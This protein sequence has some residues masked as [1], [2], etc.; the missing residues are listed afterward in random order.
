M[1]KTRPPLLLGTVGVLIVLG[2]VTG[3]YR[4]AAPEVTMTP[5]GGAEAVPS[6]QEQAATA[7]AESTRAA[8]MAEETPTVESPTSPPPTSTPPPTGTTPEITAAPTFTPA[9]TT[10]TPTAVPSSTGQTTHVVQRGENLFRIALRYG[11][12][13]NAVASANGIANPALIYVGQT[14][15]I[16]AP[17]QTPSPPPA[18]GTTYVVQRG[19]NLF[20]IALRYNLSYQY[21]AQHNG[22]AN[23]SRIYVGQV[24]RI[25]PH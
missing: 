6:V 13:V 14:L 5:A 7:A 1:K 22:I 16:P 4:P 17:G 15:T 8:E 19:D 25:P 23:P 12:T 24:L 2:L 11:T 10:S 3:C 21:L 9:P 18:G 20:R